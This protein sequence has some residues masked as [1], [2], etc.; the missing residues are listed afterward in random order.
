MRRFK[1]L[2]TKWIMN[3]VRIAK[4]M[5]ERYFETFKKQCKTSLKL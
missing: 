3:K 2:W 5:Y 1:I 4:G